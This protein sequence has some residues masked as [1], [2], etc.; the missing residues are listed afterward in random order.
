MKNISA[1]ITCI[2]CACCLTP[3][4]HADSFGQSVC[5]ATKPA[6][7]GALAITCF[8]KDNG[9]RNAVRAGEGMLIAYGAAHAIQQTCIINSS[10]D[11]AHSFPSKRTAVAFA[12]ATSLSDTYPKQ[13]W[14]AYTGASLIGWSTV[15]VNGHT[16][17]DVLAG[18]ALGMAVG[19][20]TVATPEGILIGRVIK[21]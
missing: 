6:L 3:T 1:L 7:I 8:S 17:S 21:F 5:D 10:S 2:L 15:A 18:A 19:K 13:K 4:A 16:W 14:M 11:Y 9:P 12:L 20:W